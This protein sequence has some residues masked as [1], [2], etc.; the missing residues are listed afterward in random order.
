MTETFINRDHLAALA[1]S[2]GVTLDETAL[3]RFDAYARLL[4]AWNE[5]INL[6]AITAPEEI[7]VKHFA[8]SLSLLQVAGLPQNA[9]LIDVGTGAGFP[10]LALK[11]ARPDLRVTLL[12][13]TKKKLTVLAD[14]SRALGLSVELLHLRAEDAGRQPAFRE[15]FDVAAARA[16][17]N[18]RELAEYCLPFVKVGGRFLAMKSAKTDAELEEAKAA[19]RLLGGKTAAVHPVAL[20]EAGARTVIEIEKVSPTPALYPRPSAKIARFPLK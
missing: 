14:V 9:A 10:G 18:L 3:D 11:I 16:V 13:S 8:D 2:F 4:C 17:A 7:V 12:D 1:A 20:Y 6:T 15:Q 5:K 19:V